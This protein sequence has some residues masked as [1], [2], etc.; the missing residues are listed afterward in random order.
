MRYNGTKGTVVGY[1]NGRHVVDLSDKILLVKR[2][3][4]MWWF[5]THHNNEQEASAADQAGESNK[6]AGESKKASKGS[7]TQAAAAAATSAKTEQ[8][9]EGKSF[10]ASAGGIRS[11]TARES[12]KSV[13]S[14]NKAPSKA[15]NSPVKKDGFAET[16]RGARNSEQA[17]ASSKVVQ[18]TPALQAVPAKEVM[19]EEVGVCLRSGTVILVGDDYAMLSCSVRCGP[20]LLKVMQPS[21]YTSHPQEEC[22]ALRICCLALLLRVLCFD[23][24]VLFDCIT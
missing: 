16:G 2:E 24:S 1:E 22:E 9:S 7:P 8:H 21:S 3:N 18:L 13:P 20:A 17:A 19:R 10:S 14:P 11:A 12:H 15:A 5:S 23:T 6:Q 4:L